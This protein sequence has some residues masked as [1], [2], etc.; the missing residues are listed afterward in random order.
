[1][2][3]KKK[4]ID[5]DVALKRLA[6][7][8]DFFKELAKGFEKD[9]IP[10]HYIGLLGLVIAVV[11]WR[12][13]GIFVRNMPFFS[14]CFMF[15]AMSSGYFLW[16]GRR[17]SLK[18]QFLSQLTE[19]FENAGLRTASGRMPGFVS[20]KEIDE[21][22]RVM[23]LNT[24]KVPI[25]TFKNSKEK[26][27]AGFFGYIDKFEEN[28]SNAVVK[29]FYSEEDFPESIELDSPYGKSNY[30]FVVGNTRSGIK[31]V[32]LID[33]PHF[34][35]AG[36]S[37]AGKSTFL[38]QVI[39]T[40]YLNN[41][42]ADF[43]MIDLKFGLESIE[44]RD[45]PRVM[46]YKTNQEALQALSG[47]QDELKERGEKIFDADCK[48]IIEYNKKVGGPDLN[49]KAAPTEIL[50]RKIVIIDE[51]AQIFLAGPDM[52]S[53][54]VAMAR[55][56]VST[57][58]AQGRA[59]GINV[60]VSTQRPDVNIIDGSIKANLQGRVCFHM[61]DNA[62]SMTILDSVRAAD[63]PDIKG[64]AI[65]RNGPE[66][67]EVQVPQIDDGKLKEIFEKLRIKT[68]PKAEATKEPMKNEKTGKSDVEKVVDT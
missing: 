52:T 45:L 51:A 31:T 33:V 67:L 18:K 11:Y 68:L 15:F 25:S 29:I 8:S 54:D 21:N 1:M 22:C 20:V 26:L 47:I 36:S 2:A 24:N 19:T 5:L 58:A 63:L 27:E 4:N 42:D 28:K 46:I 35:V 56:I 40:L 10:H 64:R 62:T 34:L 12:S 9:T 66:L 7:A 60:I 39:T 59:V 53:A 65:F 14:R 38:K 48:N 44:F 50:R 30:S 32:N 49:G 3:E 17:L 55:G 37:N 16:A 41:S 61:S 6:A 23:T 13:N 57:L 43:V